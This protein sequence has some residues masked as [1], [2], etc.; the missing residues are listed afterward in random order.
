MAISK[1]PEGSDF[2]DVKDAILIASTVY[3][4]TEEAKS[5]LL[6]KLPVNGYEIKE[7]EDSIHANLEVEHACS[8][9][10]C[11]HVQ[12]SWGV[13]THNKPCAFC[14]K[15]LYVEFHKG[16]TIR[17]SFVTN[18]RTDRT[19]VTLKIY[20]YDDDRNQVLVYPEPIEEDSS[21]FATPLNKQIDALEK[22]KGRYSRRKAIDNGQE[23]EVLSIPFSH[24]IDEQSVIN[25]R[26]ITGS[27]QYFLNVTIHNGVVYGIFDTIPFPTHIAVSTEYINKK[28]SLENSLAHEI[29]LHAAGQSS[30]VDFY[31][32][33]GRAAFF[34]TEISRMDAF[35]KNCVAIDYNKWKEFIV[36]A[37]MDGP[38]FIRSLSKWCGLQSGRIPTPPR[39]EPN[40]FNAIEAGLRQKRTGVLSLQEAISAQDG[41]KD[42]AKAFGVALQDGEQNPND[43]LGDV[44]AILSCPRTT[45][46]PK[47][48]KDGPA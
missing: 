22:N 45:P 36:T 42:L 30:R 6:N 2:L 25:T 15:P 3:V 4:L 18:G 5:N 14:N 16:E 26:K 41:L 11:N 20:G 7:D 44:L 32:Q 24:T 34:E 47:E 28:L 38:N 9:Y 31:H 27:K 40:M 37:P 35:V 8:C 33:D 17:F 43:V 21:F 23:I 13:L 48:P 29:I 1:L 46:V 19:D 39:E 10:H 12:S